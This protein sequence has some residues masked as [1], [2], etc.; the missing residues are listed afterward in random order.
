M[1]KFEVV[2]TAWEDGLHKG[3]RRIEL[4]EYGILNLSDIDKALDELSTQI[5]ENKEKQ[6]EIMVDDDIPF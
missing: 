1:I 6:R 3:R 5:R 4:D 2:I